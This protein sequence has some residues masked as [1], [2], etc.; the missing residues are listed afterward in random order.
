[1]K[2]KLSD[3]NDHLFMQ[4]ERLNDDSLTHEQID[5]EQKRGEAMVAVA[6]QIVRN[7]ALQMAAA[8]LAW[9]AG[10]DPGPYLP[11]VG[12]EKR[13]PAIEAKNGAGKRQ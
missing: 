13:Q 6:D 5:K 12:G 3:L 8:K 9:D 11:Q 2:N 7:A 4:L 10:H 1:M